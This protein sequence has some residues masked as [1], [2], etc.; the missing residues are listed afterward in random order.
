MC[1]EICQLFGSYDFS[2]S[3]LAITFA[4]VSVFFII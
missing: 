2:G 3:I 4:R 1:L